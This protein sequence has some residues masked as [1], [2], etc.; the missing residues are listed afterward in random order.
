MTTKGKKT[1]KEQLEELAREDAIFAY[2][3]GKYSDDSVKEITRKISRKLRLLYDTF[4][5]T[6]D[7]HSILIKEIVK[8]PTIRKLVIAEIVKKYYL[9]EFFRTLESLE[10]EGEEVQ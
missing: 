3:T 1:G 5:P 8:D 10:M 4:W 7:N 6:D 9:T 2:G